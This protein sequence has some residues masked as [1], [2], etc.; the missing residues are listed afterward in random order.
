MKVTRTGEST[1]VDGVSKNVYTGVLESLAEDGI[2]INNGCGVG[3]GYLV[4]NTITYHSEDN[5]FCHFS[6]LKSQ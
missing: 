1:I 5:R 3:G 4:Y 6:R 2:N